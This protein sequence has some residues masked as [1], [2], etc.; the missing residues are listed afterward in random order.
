MVKTT[1]LN[2]TELKPKLKIKLE[3]IINKKNNL[4]IAESNFGLY[5]FQEPECP[6]KDCKYKGRKW[7]CYGEFY[8]ECE[9]YKN[10]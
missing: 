5:P 10:E 9:E 8:V 1:K 3:S 7:Q 6:L 4:G 2:L